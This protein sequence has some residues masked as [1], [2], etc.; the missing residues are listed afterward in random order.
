MTIEIGLICTILGAA[1]GYLTYKRNSN[2]DLQEGASRQTA[3][4][5]KLDY[6]SKGVDD[7]RI[8]IKTQDKR[9]T[10]LAEKV[11]RIEESTKSAHHRLDG[12]MKE[13]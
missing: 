8:D 12:I 5:T 4:D 13:G 1:I 2:K 3:V 11:V 10:D 6:I 7:I 9:I